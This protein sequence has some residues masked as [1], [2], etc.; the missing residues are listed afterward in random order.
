MTERKI[1]SMQFSMLLF[2]A[3][4]G[5]SLTQA[6]QTEDHLALLLGMVLSWLILLP[7]FFLFR[8][9]GLFSALR[10]AG[11]PLLLPVVTLLFLLCLLFAA[12]SIRAFSYFMTF[13]LHFCHISYFV[14]CYV[15]FV[16]FY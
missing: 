7:A 9:R 2:T 16:K 4:V 15:F 5:A 13:F 12:Q 14:F 10:A 11:K 8:R 6:M 3:L 1:S